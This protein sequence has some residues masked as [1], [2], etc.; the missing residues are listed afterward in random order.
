MTE[1]DVIQPSASVASTGL[2]IRFIGKHCYGY[3]GTISVADTETDLI[4]SN[5]GSNYIVASWSV[6]YIEPSGAA[7]DYR[8]RLY[9]NGE[10]IAS[11][12]LGEQRVSNPNVTSNVSDFVIPPRTHIKITGENVADTSTNVIA[13]TI[14]GRVYGD[15]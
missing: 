7:D 10:V 1:A 5:S 6:F 12:Q 3:S 13:S 9:F 14:I 11:L 4:N 15:K 8:F 2:G